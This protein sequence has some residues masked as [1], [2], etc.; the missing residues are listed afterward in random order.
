MEMTQLALSSKKE[1]SVFYW[2]GRALIVHPNDLDVLE[3]HVQVLRAFDKKYELFFIYEN[4]ASLNPKDRQIQERISVLQLDIGAPHLAINRMNRS[5]SD[6]SPEQKL[7]AM[8]E[9]GAFDVRW[10]DADSPIPPNRFEFA[11]RSIK[12]LKD[13]LSYARQINAPAINILTIEADLIVA[14]EKRRNWEKGI[15]LYESLISR[16]KVVPSYAKLSAAICY[17]GNHDYIPAQVILQELHQDQ[18][19]ELEIMVPLHFNCLKNKIP[20]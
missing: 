11:D 5:P 15:T 16:N 14:Y 8:G 20:T 6:Y 17:Q 4:L 12:D 19:N 2:S 9:V 7:R 18:P 13:A 3:Q 1:F 10:A